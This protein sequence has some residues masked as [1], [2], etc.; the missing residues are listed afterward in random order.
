MDK[1]GVASEAEYKQQ[2]KIDGTIMYHTHI[3][4]STLKITVEA[5]A[6]L[7]RTAEHTGFCIDRAGICLDRRMGLPKG[8]RKK[9]PAETGPIMESAEDW[10]QLGN[11]VPIQP[12][13]GDFMIG[14]PSSTENTV[15]A[16]RA[17]ITTIGNLSQFFAH[18]V[19]G[20]RDKVK[21]STETVRA[22][23][24]MCALR[25]NGT[26]IHSY[27]EDGFSA[28]FQDCATIAGWAYLER[29]IVEDLLG[30][31]LAHCIGGLTSDPIKRAGWVF[32]LDVIHEHESLG[33]MIY[34]DT[35]SFMQDFSV[36][37]G[38]V[39]EYLMWDIVAQLACPTGHA[40]HPLPLTEALRIPSA[41]EIAEAQSFGRRIEK[42]AKQLHPHIDLSASYAFSDKVVAL[43]KK[44][45]VHALE[46]L[47]EAGVDTKDP[48]QMLYVL[49]E[50]GP[51]SF[52]ELFGSRIPS[53][54]TDVQKMS[55]YCL[56]EHR[57]FFSQPR[58]RKVFQGRRLLIASTDVH[59]F[60]IGIIH[61]LLSEAGA[62]MINL[63]AEKNP[64]D[65]AAEA[66]ASQADAILISTHNGMALDYAK[67]LRQ[68]LMKRVLR[69]PV[70]M[71][72]VLNQKLED[73]MLPL[74]VSDDLKSLGFHA[75]RRLKTGLHKMLELKN[76]KLQED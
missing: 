16:L 20:W 32:A 38:I 39:A 6:Q 76:D 34:G 2:S 12:H 11:V 13:M 63:G 73:R 29:Y 64:D 51:A 7:H 31:R 3:G 48:V 59:E 37:Q 75:C 47:K 68:E 23:A 24:I 19:P 36:N 22:L 42:T 66:K 17:G 10:D 28:H 26:L 44:V 56:E 69:I 57:D 55:R 15:N 49:K 54:P 5:L 62:E 35:I 25:P 53:L 1:M 41:E 27:L 46:G 43:G 50:L 74:D 33:S 8:S 45:F 71:G 9:V 67:S 72:G 14:F 65:V 58:M 21:T 70:Y 18:E 30:G 61:K 40:V 52:E 4:M 60:A